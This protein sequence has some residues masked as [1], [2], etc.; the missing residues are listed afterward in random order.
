MRAVFAFFVVT[1][2]T[3]VSGCATTDGPL[4]YF[5]K[6]GVSLVAYQNDED[7]C[8]RQA[9]EERPVTENERTA[10]ALGGF[11]GAVIQGRKE[12][13]KYYK[14]CMEK[15]GYLERPLS[16]DFVA[17]LEG[18]SEEERINKVHGLVSQEFEQ[19]DQSQVQPSAGPDGVAEKPNE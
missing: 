17:S 8:K 13:R 19:S 3:A 4:T 5:N 16:E 2:A 15:R 7:D 1:V 11:V 10:A 14:Y 9:I 18:L 6:P 12:A